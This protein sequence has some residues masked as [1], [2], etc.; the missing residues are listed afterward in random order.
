MGNRLFGLSGATW[1]TF[2]LVQT[3]AT[4]V[5]IGRLHAHPN[6]KG[7]LPLLL[8]AG[9][10]FL[11][12]LWMIYSRVRSDAT[13]HATALRVGVGCMAVSVLWLTIALYEIFAGTKSIFLGLVSISGILLWP[14][15]FLLGAVLLA[16]R[17]TG[18]APFSTER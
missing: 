18:Q 2:V 15:L 8:A 11:L 3:L 5:A 17:N 14:P 6:L 7:G 10:V 12:M 16:A 13:T 9:L 1:A 4:I